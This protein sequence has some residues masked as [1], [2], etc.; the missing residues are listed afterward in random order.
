MG[1]QPRWGYVRRVFETR[2][3]IMMGGGGGF[4]S[5]I[6]RIHNRLLIRIGRPGIPRDSYLVRLLELLGHNILE[7]FLPFDFHVNPF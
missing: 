4:K 1:N 2:I 6:P 7:H 3:K 5:D